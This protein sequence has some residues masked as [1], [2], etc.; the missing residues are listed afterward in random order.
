MNFLGREFSEGDLFRLKCVKGNI[1]TVG[2]SK[3]QLYFVDGG[4]VNT[5]YPWKFA[6]TISEILLNDEPIKL[7]LK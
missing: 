2:V 4:S 3:D 6:D 1:Y 7:E 5:S